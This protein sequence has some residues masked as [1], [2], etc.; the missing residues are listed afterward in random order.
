VWPF[1]LVAVLVGV[2]VVIGG[3]RDGIPAWWAG[4]SHG[5]TEGGPGR[6]H[7]ILLG[8]LLIVLGWGL[9][10]RRLVA[11]AAMV[12]LLGSAALGVD[13][14][15]WGALVVGYAIGLVLCHSAFGTRPDRSHLRAALRYGGLALVAAVLYGIAAH[16]GLAP[17]LGWP[18]SVL[19]VTLVLVCTALR[20]APAPEPSG[21]AERARVR[22]LVGRPDADT[23]APFALRADKTYLFSEDGT[24]AVGYRVLLGVAVVGGDPV[25]DPA[26]FADVVNRFLALCE[27]RGWRPAVLGARGDLVQLWNSHRLR[28]IGIG[29][30]VVLEVPGFGLAG[31]KM[32]NVR[33][34][35]A[36]TRNSGVH[37]CVVRAGELSDQTRAELAT[38]SA[39]SLGSA[40]ERGFSMIQDGLFDAR[41]PDALFVLAVQDGRVV[42]FQRY[43]DVGGS[44]ALSLDT[45]RREPGRFNGLNERMIVDVAEYARE[46]GIG[47]VSLN[48][49][50]FRE[51][52]DKGAQRG[53]VERVGYRLLHLLDPLIQVESLYLFNAKFRPGYQPRS[54]V[55]G[56][57]MALP[58]VLFALLGLEF[59]L[60]Y[61][62][63]RKRVE[64]VGA[65]TVD[66]DGATAEPFGRQAPVHR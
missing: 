58:R 10:R 6:L 31:R 27:R 42:G 45:M 44:A 50:A 20:S 28:S 52:L 66:P 47:R 26:A 2:W 65:P 1:G 64:A 59:A 13:H 23:L 41:H 34:A 25:G 63:R 56:T 5:L 35:V 48:F 4:P 3:L 18:T 32:R 60:P 62:V 7:A 57:W 24:A 9:E 36:R 39:R 51:L 21:E 40:R 16:R 12:L 11:W 14:T 37:T 55:I 61:D 15:P 17:G 49:A 53:R 43:L 22:W 8:A 54:V 33:Q 38:L 30:E 19:A 46:R 29:D